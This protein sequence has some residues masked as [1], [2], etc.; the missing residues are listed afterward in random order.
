MAKIIKRICITLAGTFLYLTPFRN[1]HV[2]I[3]GQRGH[4][5]IVQIDMND[6]T[7]ASGI[8]FMDLT[9]TT[10]NQIPSFADSDLCGFSGGFAAAS[11]T[12]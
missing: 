11:C 1:E 9:K 3:N 7:G 4:G 5:N 12:S 6:F 2:P 8:T 10:R